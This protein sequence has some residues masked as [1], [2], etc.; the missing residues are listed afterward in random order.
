[1]PIRSPRR[2]AGLLAAAAAAAALLMAGCSSSGSSGTDAAKS[3]GQSA[4]ANPAVSA[5][6]AAAEAL[7]TANFKK[8]FSAAHPYASIKQAIMDTFPQGN[9]PKIENYA[10]RTFS[11]KVI[12]PGLTKPNADRSAWIQNIVKTALASGAVASASPG[13]AKVPGVSGSASPKSSP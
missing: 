3:A 5:D 11:L 4:L 7:L 12:H 1:M 10:V 6:I 2:I 8:D 9:L 13:T